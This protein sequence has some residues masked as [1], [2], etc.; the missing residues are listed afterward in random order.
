MPLVINV[1]LSRKASENY[2]ST[3]VSINVSA[4]LDQSLLARPAELQEQVA[5]LYEQAEAALDRQANG[6]HQEPARPATSAVAAGANEQAPTANG[7]NGNG[8]GN[9]NGRSNGQAA[10]AAMTQSQSRAINAIAQRLGIDPAAECREVFSWDLAKLTI[11][12]ASAVIDH[13][14]ALAPTPAQP[15]DTGGH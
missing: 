11:R 8:G 2:Q 10:A 7:R 9:G 6:T 12:Q 4:E 1:G 14:K 15:A 3:G 13:L 5:S